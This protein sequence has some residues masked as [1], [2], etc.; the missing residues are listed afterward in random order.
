MGFEYLCPAPPSELDLFESHLN[1]LIISESLFRRSQKIV[2]KWPKLK[3]EKLPVL[4]TPK[5]GFP[6]NLQKRNKLQVSVIF[7]R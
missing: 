2:Q 7:K 3:I 5:D 1:G 6:I 4:D